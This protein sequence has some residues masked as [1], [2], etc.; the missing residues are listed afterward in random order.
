M[1]TPKYMAPEQRDRPTEVD[2]RADI[3]SLGVVFYEMLTGKTPDKLIEPPSRKV[4]IDVRLDEVVLRA[5]EREPRRRYQ[6]ASEVKTVVE[7]IAGDSP[8][9]STPDRFAA[10]SAQTSQNL[11]PWCRLV[12][13]MV[14]IRFTSPV[15]IALT[16]LS[17]LGFLGFLGNLRYLDSLWPP[18]AYCAHLSGL[19]GLFGLIGFAIAIEF[20]AARAAQG[21]FGNLADRVPAGST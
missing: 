2:H 19:F 14:G 8:H 12:E 20:P 11:S 18:L 3:Y 17:A 6:Q 10:A 13:L 1:G 5:L 15:A 9:D 21:Q 7:T 16:N 4:V